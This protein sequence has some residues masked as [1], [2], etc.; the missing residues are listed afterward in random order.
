MLLEAQK[1]RKTFSRLPVLK[2]IDF[3]MEKGEIVSIVGPSGA[4]KT[5]LLNILSTLDYPDDGRILLDGQDVLKLK[6][7]AKSHFRN[8]HIGI[9]FQFHNLLPEFSALENICIPGFIAGRPKAEVRDQARVL[10]QILGIK[11]RADHKPNE[12]S[13]GEQQ[14]TSVARA[15]INGPKIIFAD[16]PSGNLD[17][18]NAQELHE[19][20][21]KLRDEG[22]GSFIIVTHNRELAGMTDRTITLKDGLIQNDQKNR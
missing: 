18:Q 10:M 11:H 8:R 2:G 19:L 6:K 5:T 4:G 12:L 1:V 7:D 3:Q 22:K 17:S 14:R 21:F 9:V 15:L 13:G 20:F 16:E